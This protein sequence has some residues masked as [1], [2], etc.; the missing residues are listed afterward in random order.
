MH[1]LTG[2]AK[3]NHGSMKI[4][5]KEIKP[6][7]ANWKFDIGYVGDAQVFFENWPAEK[8]LKLLRKFYP[9]WSDRLVNNLVDRFRLPLETRAK[10]L[11]S[12]NRVK[13]S[14][15]SALA[16]LPKLLL[17]DEPTSGLDPVVRKE[18]MD[19]LFET[20]EDG[21]RAIFYSIHILSDI[22]RIADE[23]AFLVDGQLISRNYKDDLTENWRKFSFQLNQ[24]NLEIDSIISHIQNKD[25]YQVISRDYQATLNH[26]Q[27]IGAQNILYTRLG[28]EEI[29]L[30][31]MKAKI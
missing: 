7:K 8:N 25:E 5:G 4:F 18:V 19:T 14:L 12:G 1:C 28:I 11:S 3:A 26:L 9:N 23:L 24:D 17:L 22:N 15:I 6:D 10:N 31:I 21:D 2:L 20:L 30:E 16:H 27:T 13:L 29:A